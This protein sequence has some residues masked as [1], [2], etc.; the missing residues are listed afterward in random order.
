M[1]DLMRQAA[2]DLWRV[3]V[4]S[5]WLPWDQLTTEPAMHWFGVPIRGWSGDFVLIEE[6][7]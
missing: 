7:Q 2:L 6:R 4:A 5:V 3:S 1:R